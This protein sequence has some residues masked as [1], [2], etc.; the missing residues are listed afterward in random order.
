MNTPVQVGRLAMRVEGENWNAYYALPD[1]MKDPV[2]LGSIRMGA[3]ADNPERKQ[4]FMM[5]MRDIVSDIIEE[6]TGHRPTWREPPCS[7]GT[8]T[9][10]ESVM[11]EMQRPD[12]SIFQELFTGQQVKDGTAKRRR[13]L[14]ESNGMTFK[15]LVQVDASKHMPHQ[16]SKE[17]ARRVRQMLRQAA[18]NAATA[19]AE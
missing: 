3:V 19:Q 9:K 7:A 8:R 5:M 16:G 17:I 14:L 6:S 18:K 12:G 10:R 11:Q 13:A 15:R 2:F 4:A 1:T